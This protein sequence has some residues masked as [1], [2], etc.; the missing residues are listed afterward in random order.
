MSKKE[1]QTTLDFF[2][3]PKVHNPRT[4][5]GVSPAPRWRTLPAKDTAAKD[6]G[7]RRPSNKK[8]QGGSFKQAQEIGRNGE[9]Q[10]PS[11]TVNVAPLKSALPRK[12]MPFTSSPSANECGP[13]FGSQRKDP[14]PGLVPEPVL[15]PEPVGVP[16]PVVVPQPVL[17]PEPDVIFDRNKN[18]VG[19]IMDPSTSSP[20]QQGSIGSTIKWPSGT[21]TLIAYGN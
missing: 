20:W 16:E 19:E 10:G 6:K 18:S 15:L 7:S 12:Q 21:F 13:N 1:T 5:G 3:K 9:T 2:L 17:L 8:S 14:K 11:S 4:E